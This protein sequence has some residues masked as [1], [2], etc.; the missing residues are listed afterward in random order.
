MRQR[1]LLGCNGTVLYKLKMQTQVGSA[2]GV[3][4]MLLEVRLHF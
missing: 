4:L 2:Q 3:T 1:K